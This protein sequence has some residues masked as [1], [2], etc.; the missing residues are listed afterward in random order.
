MRRAL[1]WIIRLSLIVAAFSAIWVAA[2]RYIN[3]PITTL[4]VI[5]RLRVGKLERDWRPLTAIS[6]NLRHA[7]IATEDSPFCRHHGFNWK[8]IY[9]AY[10]DAE[11]RR[12]GSS[13][14]QQTAKNAFLWPDAS[15]LRKGV[16]AGFA[17]LIEL[18]WPKE[19]ILEVYLNIAEFDAGV[20]GAEAAARHYF[21]VSASDLSLDQ[22]TRLAWLL[23]SPRS[24]DPRKANALTIE[25]TRNDVQ[26]MRR[27]DQLDCVST[28]KEG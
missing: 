26:Y 10:Q 16:E 23:P 17:I 6:P 14:T 2:Y 7:V 4:M 19:R 11:R 20:F 18:I 9:R 28:G 13:I 22:A 27:R 8:E 12:G 1:G 3:P 24:R 15:W 5:E 25:K 21:G